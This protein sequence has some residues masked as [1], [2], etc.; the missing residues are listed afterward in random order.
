MKI[1]IYKVRGNTCII[2]FERRNKQISGIGYID[3]E[4]MDKILSCRWSINSRGYATYK[5]PNKKTI[6]L[7]SYLMKSKYIDH[8]NRNPLDNRKKNLR[9]STYSDNQHNRGMFRNNTSGIKGIFKF[10]DSNGTTRY[11]SS[12]RIRGKF[13]QKNCKTK[14]EAIYYRKLWEKLL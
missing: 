2:Y 3:K 9:I 11:M 4:D 10:T 1:N 6:R 8:I 14:K 13:Y 7:H 5:P 12:I